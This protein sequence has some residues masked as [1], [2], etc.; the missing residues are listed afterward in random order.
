MLGMMGNSFN[1]IKYIYE[2]FVVNI[3]LNCEIL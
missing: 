2:K 1:L 3:L